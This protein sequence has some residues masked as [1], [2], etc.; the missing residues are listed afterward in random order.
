MEANGYLF[1]PCM[2][3]QSIYVHA[4]YSA[5]TKYSLLKNFVTGA[6]I[7]SPYHISLGVN[8]CPGII[9]RREII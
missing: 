4:T 3:S 2:H 8:F 6:H 5:R 9:F 1:R 7:S